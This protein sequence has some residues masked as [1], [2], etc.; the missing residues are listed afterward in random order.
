MKETALINFYFGDGS[1]RDDLGDMM[2]YKNYEPND[3]IV[4]VVVGPLIFR[5][6]ISD[7][8][9]KTNEKYVYCEILSKYAT[10]SNEKAY[11]LSVTYKDAHDEKGCWNKP[12]REETKGNAGS[13]LFF[14]ELCSRDTLTRTDTP[15][16][17]SIDVYKI[18]V[19]CDIEIVPKAHKQAKGKLA[20]DFGEL[21]KSEKCTDFTIHADNQKFRCHKLV[22]TTRSSVF[23]HMLSSGML[24]SQN[25]EVYLTDISPNT[26]S[27]LLSY[28]YTDNVDDLPT[29]AQSLLPVAEKYDLD[30]LKD[31][32]GE[33]LTQQIDLQTVVDLALLSDMYNVQNLRTSTVRYIVKNKDTLLNNPTW[34]ESFKNS[35]SILLDIVEALV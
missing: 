26:V 1:R 11:E 20:F 27:D 29:K 21:F 17:R 3:M 19:K 4:V 10:A 16:N 23:D 28:L 13:I 34:R 32:C 5:A 33:A 9:S 14:G 30:G 24:E 35:P 18:S 2:Q 12:L 8:L 25:S 31:L 15:I 7:S 6:Y 22:L